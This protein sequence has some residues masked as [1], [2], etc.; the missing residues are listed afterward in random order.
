MNK[1]LHLRVNDELLELIR[2]TAVHVGDDVSF[3]VRACCRSFFNNRVVQNKN[4]DL[5]YSSGDE[6]L[7]V[8][9]VYIPRDYK[10]EDLRKHIACR[11]IEELSKPKRKEFIPK[12]DTKYLIINY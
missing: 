9:G 2:Q 7:T 5:Y 3:V 11:C 10:I 12:E 8:R 1:T 4:I 6:I